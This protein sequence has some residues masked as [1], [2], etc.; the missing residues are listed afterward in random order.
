MINIE[1]RLK[2]LT[3]NKGGIINEGYNES[4]YCF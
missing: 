3:G 2:Y 1:K 4:T